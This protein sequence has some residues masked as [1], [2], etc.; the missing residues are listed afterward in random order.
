MLEGLLKLSAFSVQQTLLCIVLLA[1]QRLP[2]LWR[3]ATKKGSSYMKEGQLNY[4]QM[5]LDDLRW[6]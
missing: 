2:V 5:F 6:N 3:Q 4:I 1:E